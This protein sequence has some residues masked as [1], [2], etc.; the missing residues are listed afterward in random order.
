MMS[1]DKYVKYFNEG[2]ELFLSVVMELIESR[3]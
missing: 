2:K 3:N 1:L